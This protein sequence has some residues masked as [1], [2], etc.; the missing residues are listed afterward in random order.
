MMR[1]SFT[2]GFFTRAD[3]PAF[4]GCKSNPNP[5]DYARVRAYSEVTPVYVYVNWNLPRTGILG[6]WACR[7][8]LE[9]ALS[10][11]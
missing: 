7:A 1:S 2:G 5:P 8:A 10:H 4:E 9:A 11:L 6:D 3:E